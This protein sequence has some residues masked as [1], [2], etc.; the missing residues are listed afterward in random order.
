MKLND[1]YQLLV[2]AADVNILG[3]GVRA[4]K[5]NAEALEV[6]SQETGLEVNTDKAKY[7]AMSRVLD[8]GRSHSIQ[9]GNSSFERVEKFKYLGT[10]TN[11]NSIQEEI[12][13]RLKSGNACYHSV[14]NLWSSSFLSRN[15][16]DRYTL[17]PSWSRVLLGK[18]T[19]L[20]LVKKFP[21]F[22]GIGGLMTLFTSARYLPLS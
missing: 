13:S 14:Q 2:Y 3:G 10:L 16:K 12:K 18:L 19:S 22:Y 15:L 5:K 4:V 20:Q 8:A 7:M 1:A 9:N 6:A 17:L 21:A 11:Q